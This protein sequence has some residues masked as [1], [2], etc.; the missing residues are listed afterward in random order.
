MSRRRLALLTSLVLFS[1]GCSLNSI[2]ASR[3]AAS[4]D[5]MARAFNSEESIKDA[6][7]AAP[8]LL[9]LLD[10]IVE[11]APSNE[12]LLVKGAEMN[13]TFAFGL[14]EEEDPSRAR[15]LYQKA[16]RYALRALEERD[17]NWRRALDSPEAE[18]RAKLDTLEADD[19]S[20]PELFW[21]AFAR[22]GEINLSRADP[23]AIADLPKVLAVME[24]LAEIVPGFFHGGPHL[25]LGV[26]YGSRGSALG[27]DPQKSA[28]H[29]AKA[30]ALT[31][32]KFPIIDVLYARTCC[33]A[34]GEKEPA[35]AR[36]EFQAALARV[37]D[38][39]LETDPQ[40]RLVAA[41]AK[42]RA[43]RLEPQ[44]DDLILPPLST[45]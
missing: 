39:R 26:Y 41:I 31:G 42:E 45:E 14:I 20:I 36:A 8:A 44:L 37:K 40:N 24:R 18:L 12:R 1:P 23:R 28:A 2:I 43:A 11:M 5:D 22:G 13:A 32:G 38:Y 25:F 21:A 27:G 10:G 6:R 19:P 34:L 7:E 4:F 9:K 35:R 15:L 33:V 3:M 16:H 29:F 17:E 30:R